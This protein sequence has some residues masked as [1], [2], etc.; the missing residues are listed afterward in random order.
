MSRPLVDLLPVTVGGPGVNEFLFNPG[1]QTLIVTVG[2]RV[3]G[4]PQRVFLRTVR[5]RAYREVA[6][7]NAQG[8]FVQVVASELAPL[9]LLLF[10]ER[11]ERGG[12]A[13]SAVY[14][15]SLPTG[16]LAMS[17]VLAEE[18]LPKDLW[19]SNL[20]AASA[21]GLSFYAVIGSRP[22]PETPTGYAVDY[23]LC[24]ISLATGAIDVVTQLE[25]PFA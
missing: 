25:T 12:T 8:D 1:S 17:P 7:P 11:N 5:E 14:S 23:R 19:V 18:S 24:K 10:A 6:V 9:A 15:L 22:K 21:D 16:A 2:H 20:V 4:N 3:R 13:H